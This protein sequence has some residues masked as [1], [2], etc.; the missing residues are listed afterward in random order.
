VEAQGSQLPVRDTGGVA[1]VVLAGGSSRRWGGVDKTAAVLGELPVLAHVVAGAT[2]RVADLVGPATVVVVA[3]DEHPAREVLA[4][5]GLPVRWTREDPPGGGPVAG[6]AAALTALD[7]PDP[8]RPGR[9]EVATV[10]VLAGDMPYA[11]SAVPRLLAALA[12][13]RAAD[14]A[15]GVDAAGVRQPLVAAYRRGALRRAVSGPGAS[16][17]RGRSLRD[18]LRGM[19][20]IEV[21]VTPRES[22]DLDTPERF[23]FAQT[24]PPEPPPARRSRAA[25]DA[26]T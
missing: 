6:L 9:C 18:V 14:G 23:A 12:T 22:L 19:A 11:G 26:P 8:S 16:A 13:S 20:L 7:E 17:S 24:Q 1:V 21:T 15:V 25:P 4:G 2:A 10:V 3:P 5:S